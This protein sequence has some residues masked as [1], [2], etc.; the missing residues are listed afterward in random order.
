MLFLV[1]GYFIVTS[2]GIVSLDIYS[3][4]N[5]NEKDESYCT[6]PRLKDPVLFGIVW[7][8]TRFITVIS[9]NLLCL[10]LFWRVRVKQEKL[11]QTT[12]DVIAREKQDERYSNYS[13]LTHGASELDRHKNHPNDVS[14]NTYMS[15]ISI[16][17]DSM[18]ES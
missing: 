12:Y 13:G 17:E 11:D 2:I 10:I 4:R 15:N 7:I 14:R 3:Y 1:V 16:N 6:L 8:I 5:Y 18:N 9:V